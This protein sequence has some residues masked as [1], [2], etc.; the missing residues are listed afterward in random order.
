MLQQTQVDTVIPYYLRFLDSFPSVMSLANAPID[1]VLAHWAGLGYYARARNL[2]KCAQRVCAEF[3]GQ[4]PR[5]SEQLATLPGIGRSTAAAIASFCFGERAA[6]LDGNVK[7]VL[8]RQFGVEGFPGA[9]A[10]EQAMWKLAD[11]LLPAEGIDT[12]TQALM[13]LGAT[14]CT[15]GRPVCLHCPVNETCVARLTGRQGELPASR[16]RKAIP[17]RSADMLVMI[18]QGNVLL[19]RRPPKGIWGGLY[20][21]PEAAEGESPMALAL[22]RSGVM[23]DEVSAL[24]PVRHTFTHFALTITPWLA[25]LPAQP[26]Q[27]TE[28]ALTWAPL[29]ALDRYGLPTPIKRVLTTLPQRA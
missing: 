21:L 23:P 24:A 10:V 14:V 7:R 6:I 12:Y 3:S 29:N 27:A 2:H 22:R 26:A 19:E 8:A 16:P 4:F 28:D 1:D 15:R 20:S 9:R 13:D 5:T 11:E 25:Q 17:E 18:A